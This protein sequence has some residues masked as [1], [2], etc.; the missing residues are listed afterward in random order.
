ML[1]LDCCQSILRKNKMC[2]CKISTRQI[3]LPTLNPEYSFSDS[4][5]YMPSQFL[6]QASGG[7]RALL[8]EDNQK[9]KTHAKVIIIGL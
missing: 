4:L 8:T 7:E 9:D 6:Y 1:Y 3:Q 2:Y 5:D